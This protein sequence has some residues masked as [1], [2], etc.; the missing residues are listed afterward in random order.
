MLRPI[1]VNIIIIHE[2]VESFILFCNGWFGMT[3][4]QMLN[5]HKTPTII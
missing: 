5:K 2:S 4:I 3:D 1:S